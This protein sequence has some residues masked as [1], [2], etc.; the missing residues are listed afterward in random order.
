MLL[1]HLSVFHF[2]SIANDYRCFV[3]GRNLGKLFIAKSCLL[4]GCK[5]G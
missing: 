4:K 5:R 1:L 3:S 2:L